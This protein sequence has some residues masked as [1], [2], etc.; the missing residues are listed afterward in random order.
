MGDTGSMLLGFVIFILCVLLVQHF[1]VVPP[2]PLSSL[3]HSAGGAQ[4]IA[5]SV[6]YLPVYDG[7]RVFVLRAS[8]G[9]SP[10][11]ADRTHLHYYLLDAGFSHSRATFIIV[12]TNVLIIALAFLMQDVAPIITLLC[13]TAL[14]SL[15]LLGVYKMRGRKMAG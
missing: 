10:L 7:V 9:I 4:M 15:V 2:A 13:I 14:V 12:C 11:K 3:V 5:L 6:L 8:K 1:P